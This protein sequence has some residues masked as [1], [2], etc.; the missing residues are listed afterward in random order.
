MPAKYPRMLCCWLLHHRLALWK[1]NVSF[2]KTTNTRQF[3]IETKKNKYIYKDMHALKVI[4]RSWL[5]ELIH[6]TYIVHQYGEWPYV[7]I[8]LFPVSKQYWVIQEPGGRTKG[9]FL[10][11][12]NLISPL[13]FQEQTTESSALEGS[14]PTDRTSLLLNFTLTASPFILFS[15]SLNSMFHIPLSLLLGLIPSTSQSNSSWCYVCNWLNL[16]LMLNYFLY[17]H[18]IQWGLWDVGENK[19]NCLQRCIWSGEGRIQE[20]E[21][22]DLMLLSGSLFPLTPLNLGMRLNEILKQL[23]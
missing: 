22:Q 4:L 19:M 18:K 1:K 10:L 5:T 7:E 12:S 21:F 2:I 13:L 11:Y 8:S 15:R 3:A 9:Y 14:L 6:S 17:S 16:L 23:W 20:R